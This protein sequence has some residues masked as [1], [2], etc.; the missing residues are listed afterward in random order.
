M[1]KK[2]MVLVI[3][4]CF[5]SAVPVFAFASENLISEAAMFDGSTVS[6]TG[7]AVGPILPRGDFSW[8]SLHDGKNAI[9]C[10]IP[11]SLLGDIRRTGG[12]GRKGDVVAV[13][14]TF[15]RS[16]PEHGGALDIHA[17]Y[18]MLESPGAALPEY[19]GT[20]KIVM[21]AVSLGVLI[22]LMIVHAFLARRK[23]I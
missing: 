5:F 10:W 21:S 11:K 4:C 19:L 13:I 8:I 3:F 18:V 14:G 15:H 2:G 16:C 7:E 12:Y 9:S 17:K 20:A 6:Y 1:M 23:K 22:C